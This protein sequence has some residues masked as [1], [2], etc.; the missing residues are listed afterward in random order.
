MLLTVLCLLA[1]VLLLLG[2]EM[3][4][5]MGIPSLLVWLFYFPSIPSIAIA[6]P[7]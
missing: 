6:L 5:V 3:F 7:R 1:A 2:F 4:L